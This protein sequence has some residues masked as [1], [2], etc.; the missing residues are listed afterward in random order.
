MCFVYL[1]TDKLAVIDFARLNS[2]R[3]HRLNTIL[4][5]GLLNIIED[6]LM[7]FEIDKEKLKD[8]IE[9]L[10]SNRQMNDFPEYEGRFSKEDLFIETQFENRTYSL[11]NSGVENSVIFLINLYN[12]IKI[13]NKVACLLVLNHQR[14]ML[15]RSSFSATSFF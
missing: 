8:S 7:C 14:F 11:C 4:N 1:L 13:N 6:K 15:W 3:Y 5:N 2:D 9:F 12:W 10:L